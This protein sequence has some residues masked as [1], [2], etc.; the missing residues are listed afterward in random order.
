MVWIQFFLGDNFM[1][2]LIMEKP[3]IGNNT[4]SFNFNLMNNFNLNGIKLP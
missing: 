1:E 4:I 3:A 2:Y